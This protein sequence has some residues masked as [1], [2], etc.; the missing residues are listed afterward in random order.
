MPKSCSPLPFSLHLFSHPHGTR[1]HLA[2]LR[3][4]VPERRR[5]GS[6]LGQGAGAGL[7]H[8]LPGGRH[9][10][11]AVGPG[12][13]EQCARHPALCRVWRGA[14]ALFGGA[15]A[16]TE[17]PVGAAPPHFWHRHRPGA[18][19]RR[20]AVCA[21]RAGRLLRR[22]HRRLPRVA[23]QRLREHSQH[24]AHLRLRGGAEDARRGHEVGLPE[25]HDHAAVVVEHGPRVALLDYRMPGLDGAQVAAAVRRDVVERL[26]VLGITLDTVNNTV[27]SKEPRAISGKD[28]SV[29]VLVI[30]TNEERMIALHTRS[31]VLGG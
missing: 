16:A 24:P 15:G 21:G 4:D 25:H 28:S 23:L 11:W 13:G 26:A 1:T 29:A 22:P 14:H 7:H 2:H 6:A 12:A 27:R 5:A 8:W 19:L 30:P 18:G 17:P 3:T 31:L 9:C 10:H 20:R